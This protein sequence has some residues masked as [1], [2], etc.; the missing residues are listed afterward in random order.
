MTLVPRLMRQATALGVVL[1]L[2]GAPACAPKDPFRRVVA[3]VGDRPVTLSQ[4]EAYLDASLLHDASA[5]TPSVA[6]L[7]RVKSRLLDDFLDEE[8]QLAEALARGIVVTEQELTDYLGADAP[9]DPGRREVAHR[10][11]MIQKLRESI[12]RAKVHVD[13]AQVDAWL[14]SHSSTQPPPVHGTLRTLRFASFPEAERVRREITSGKLSFLEAGLSYADASAGGARDIDLSTLPERMAEVVS[15]MKPGQVS[16]P[17][18]FESS[19]L[20]LLLEA[21]DDPTAAEARRRERV[22]S[23]LAL[24]LSQAAT[25]GLLRDLHAKTKIVVHDKLLPFHYVHDVPGKV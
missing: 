16:P 21:V 19:V 13:D 9:A 23:E 6:D 24:E 4:V 7:E 2:A 22:R 17:V 3:E 14:L 5:E 20:L 18:P 12:V 10:E 15:K 1:T 25:E 8:L 11:L